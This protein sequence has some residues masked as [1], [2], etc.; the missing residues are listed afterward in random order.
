MRTIE[1]ISVLRLRSEKPW[2]FGLS[3]EKC[4][5]AMTDQHGEFL[6]TDTPKLKPFGITQ[7]DSPVIAIGRI[8]SGT[9]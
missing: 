4:T 1:A 8:Q 5:T 6:S 2:A 9:P 7:F 3:A